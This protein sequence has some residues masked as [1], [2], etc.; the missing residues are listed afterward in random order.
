MYIPSYEKNHCLGDWAFLIPLIQSILSLP[1]GLTTL[2]EIGREG[3]TTQLESPSLNPQGRVANIHQMPVCAVQ[4]NCAQEEPGKAA[5][6]K[7]PDVMF[8]PC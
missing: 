6:R 5:G 8:L 7:P 3:W 4:C 1:S 2:T